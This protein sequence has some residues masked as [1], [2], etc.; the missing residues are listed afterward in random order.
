MD[1]EVEKVGILHQPVA[2]IA[3]HISS[4]ACHR[5]FIDT[6]GGIR[7]DEGFIDAKNL[8]ITAAN[9]TG[10]QRAVVAEEVFGRLLE[11]DAVGLEDVG[12]AAELAGKPCE[13]VA[14]S[15]GE[16]RLRRIEH[17][18]TK[19]IV[20]SNRKPVDEQSLVFQIAYLPCGK[21]LVYPV[22]RTAAHVDKP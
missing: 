6:Q 13:D 20:V 8:A 7:N 9:R 18:G 21:Q 15:F 19:I 16:S 1:R 10:A 17:T 14:L 5:T 2:T 3:H 11:D 12:E 4:P 22:E